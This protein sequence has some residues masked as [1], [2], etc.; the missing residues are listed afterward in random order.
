[1]SV[2]ARRGH[3]TT[4]SSAAVASVVASSLAAALVWSWQGV[5]PWTHDRAALALLWASARPDRPIS[6][7]SP[8][9][10]VLSRSELLSNLSIHA[11]R[12]SPPA[13][14]LHVPMLPAGRYRVE[15]EPQSPQLL[16][17]SLGPDA[18]PYATWSAN[19]QPPHTFVA[20]FPIW[21]ARITTPPIDEQQLRVVLRPIDVWPARTNN[22]I[23][24]RHATPYGPLIVYSLDQSS[25]PEPDGLWLGGNRDSVLA[26]TDREGHAQAA[27]ARLEAG[28]APVTITVTNDAGWRHELSL[29]AHDQQSI[30]IPTTS[31]GQPR[32][33]RF[34]VTGGF[35][36]PNGRRLGVWVS[37]EPHE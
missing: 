30:E 7:A 3:P 2:R 24:A 28:D 15:V 4:L 6:V 19:A 16:T 18:W 12:T 20:A 32:P 5:S 31:D 26:I 37:F 1:M 25:Y 27:R 11:P 14:L 13:A 22:H 36:A 9:P 21:T 10:H 23:V 17:L 33:L 35:M 29:A 34:T 8:G